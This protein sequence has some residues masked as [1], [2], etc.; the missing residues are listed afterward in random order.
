MQAILL[1]EKEDTTRE[2]LQEMI[3]RCGAR[4]IA[5][6]NVHEA[7][8]FLGAECGCDL[9][10]FGLSALSPEGIAFLA[11]VRRSF[12]GLP[13]VIMSDQNDL[14]DHFKVASLDVQKCVSRRVRPGDIRRIVGQVRATG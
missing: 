7:G 13:C 8:R 1:V 11:S 6:A 2:G 14:E 4:C 5:V 10:L 3:E 12:P 9:L